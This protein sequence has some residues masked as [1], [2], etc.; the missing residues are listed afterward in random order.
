MIGFFAPKP[1]IANEIVRIF[2]LQ[3]SY[4]SQIG[5]MNL[6]FP[7]ISGHFSNKKHAIRN[8]RKTE[9]GISYHEFYENFTKAKK[10]IYFREIKTLS[11]SNC[12]SAIDN[13]LKVL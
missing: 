5:G 11:C 8:S 4:T 10:A 12:K 2:I 7:I 13:L 3:L 1:Y 9:C 6:L